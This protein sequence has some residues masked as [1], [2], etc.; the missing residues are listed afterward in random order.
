MKRSGSQLSFKSVNGWGGKRRGAGRPNLSGRV[1][2]MKRE[3]VV[4]KTPV[5]LTLKI[6]NKKWNLRCGDVAKAFKISA[7][8][9][10]V[11]GLRILHYSILRDHLHLVVEVVDNESLTRGMR[12]FGS[13]FGKAIRSL[14]GGKG[15]VF[16]GRFHLTVISSPTQMRNTLAY[17]LQNYSQH[18]N[19][20]EHIDAYSSAPYFA[21][22]RRLL[23]RRVG[24]IV[25][26]HSIKP[27]MPPHLCRPNSWLAREG[28][29]RA[30]HV[31]R[32][33]VS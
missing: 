31:T 12:S 13:S 25:A 18:S 21:D 14:V 7:A 10:K 22:W 24:P 11:F 2:H 1:S 5:H 16:K 19:L 6:A 30:T 26:R 29:K 33:R 32:S 23:G 20:L 28:W 9:A 17:V 8:K 4:L 27:S 15:P 3:N